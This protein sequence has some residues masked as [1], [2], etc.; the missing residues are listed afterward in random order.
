MSAIPPEAR[1]ILRDGVLCYLATSHPAAPHVTPV[2][3]A[4]D[5]GRIWVTTSR[6]SVKARAWRRDRRV[7]GLIRSGDRAVSFRGTVRTY[8]A[9]DLS[10]WP[11]AT[12]AGPAIVRAATRFSMKNAR[13]FAGY[14]VD[15]NRVPFAWTPPGRVFVAVRPASGFVLRDGDI[16]GCWGDAGERPVG[17]AARFAAP[18]RRRALDL[19]V[20]EA[21]R[22]AIGA[23]GL[24]ALTVADATGRS[25]VIPAA[26]RRSAAANR[27]DVALPSSFARAAGAVD[28]CPASLT[29]DRASS[30]RATEMTGLL[31]QG[32]ADVFDPMAVRGGKRALLARLQAIGGVPVT[33]AMLARVEA[34]R[35]VWW[36]GWTSGTVTP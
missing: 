10:S 2:V 28:G 8:D 31:V 11:A 27:Y 20:P 35:L 18:A 5:A 19:G 26:W 25:T 16:V 7:A 1:R 33:D 29:L 13:F 4:F 30:W 21:V 6:R 34:R 17:S 32:H 3:Y 15:A 12:V 36:H 23:H 14:A 22:R 24:G 9:L